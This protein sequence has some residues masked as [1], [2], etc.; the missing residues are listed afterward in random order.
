M[1]KDAEIPRS[2]WEHT[3]GFQETA[4][5]SGGFPMISPATNVKTKNSPSNEGK[6]RK[7]DWD[8]NRNENF[9]R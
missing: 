9:T 8:F 7:K 4:S 2:T 6:I 5:F 3:V 1:P